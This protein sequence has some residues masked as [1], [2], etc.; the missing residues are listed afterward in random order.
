[1]SANMPQRPVGDK[2]S[3]T[4]EALIPVCRDRDGAV[5]SAVAEALGKIGDPRAITVLIKFFRDPSKTVRETAGT[6]LISIG[7]PS[8]DPLI[9]CLKDKDFVVRLSR[10][11]RTRGMTTDY[12]S[13]N[14]VRILKLSMP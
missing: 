5:K 1:V 11:P 8:V 9:D 13:P 7:Q 4:V 6:A 3:E 12:Q 2:G 14:L 10:G